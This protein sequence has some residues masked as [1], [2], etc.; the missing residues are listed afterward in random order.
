MNRIILYHALEGS[1]EMQLIESNDCRTLMKK[2]GIIWENV[3]SNEKKSF[4]EIFE[5]VM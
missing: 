5:C 3:T 2:L 4:L 1:K